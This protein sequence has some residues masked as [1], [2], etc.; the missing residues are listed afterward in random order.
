V[1]GWRKTLLALMVSLLAA[2]V[3]ATPTLGQAQPPQ[4]QLA[5]S[6]PVSIDPEVEA[7]SNILTGVSCASPSLCVA[8]DHSGE[9]ISSTDPGGGPSAW[10]R[11][12]VDGSTII[13]G[14]SC[15]STSLCVAVDQR[16]DVLTSTD[17]T[18]GATAWSVAEVQP[19]GRGL[20]GVSC[21]TTTTCVAVSAAGQVLVSSNP[22]G[23][24]GAWRVTP[25]D[26]SS[27]GYLGANDIYAVSCAS[28]SLCVAVDFEGNAVAS[29]EPFGGAQAW[30]ASGIDADNALYAVSCP[31]A[32]LCVATDWAGDVVAS[33][34]P[35]AGGGAWAAAKIA[36]GAPNVHVGG[37]SC[38]SV[39]LCVAVDEQGDAFT[40]SDPAGG[41]ATWAPADIDGANDLSGVS[42]PSLGLCVA[43]DSAG[44]VVVGAEHPAL[45]VATDGTGAGTVRGAGISCPSRCSHSY[46]GGA[47]VTLVAGAA[48]GSTFTGWGGA[49]GGRSSC[50]VTMDGEQLVTA[51]FVA[52]A[53]RLRVVRVRLA[54][55][56]TRG[57]ALR[58]SCTVAC[59][60]TVSVRLGGGGA[61]AGTPVGASRAS[62]RARHSRT[63]LVGLT[64]SA[65]R[66]LGGVSRVALVVSATASYRGVRD[67]FSRAISVA[68]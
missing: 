32:A 42:C 48:P 38:P 9:V 36:A 23:G 45:S 65:K 11:A 46:A 41:A 17:P 37:V 1:H 4:T 44:Q 15:P 16:G 57:L 54:E 62:L 52:S 29:T 25:V 56:L 39:S 27:T 61:T 59:H 31:S 53:L 24:A 26:L 10:T 21:P 22:T 66:R 19:H 14:V 40:S 47:T 2:T 12:R 34:N 28:P 67:T 35:T 43:V 60:V 58:A 33:S 3:A 49:C 50:V 30:T 63:L 8:V 7:G 55:L 68:R 51:G 5:W 13:S 64:A 20:N 6:A 18:A